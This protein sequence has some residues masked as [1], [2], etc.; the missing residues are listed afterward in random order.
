MIIQGGSVAIALLVVDF[1][2][3][4]HGSLAFTWGF[5]PAAEMSIVVVVH[6]VTTFFTVEGVVD[7]ELKKVSDF[8]IL[9]NLSRSSILYST[10]PKAVH[11]SVLFPNSTGADHQ[12]A[13]SNASS[14]SELAKDRPLS[15]GMDRHEAPSSLM[16]SSS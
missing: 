15:S 3:A 12:L 7:L 6:I 8:S 1:P 11:F 13:N 2:V 9:D 5:V 14:S 10:F 16:T 4:W